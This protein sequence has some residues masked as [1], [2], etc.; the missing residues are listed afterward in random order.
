MCFMCFLHVLHTCAK[1][2]LYAHGRIVGLLG[3]VCLFAYCL[4]VCFYAMCRFLCFVCL[5]FDSRLEAILSCFYLYAFSFTSP[6]NVIIYDTTLWIKTEYLLCLM[7]GIKRKSIKFWA[8]HIAYK[9][10]HQKFFLDAS[11]HLYKR[12]CPSVGPS[13]CHA[14]QK[15]KI[16]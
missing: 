8:N 1:C 2:A 11:S 3:L 13:A 4:S 6:V 14:F 5:H 12:V 9:T 16:K 10:F 7:W 15:K